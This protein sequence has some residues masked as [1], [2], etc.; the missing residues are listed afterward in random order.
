[1]PRYQ[2]VVDLGRHRGQLHHRLRD[3]AARVFAHRLARGD[4]LAGGGVGAEQDPVAARAL[5]RFEHELLQAVKHVRAFVVQPAP[6]GGDVGQQR[7]LVQVV[8]D[9]FR[10][11]GVD[12]LVV[13]HPVAHR[14]GDHDTALAGGVEHAGDAQHRVRVELQRI[15]ELVVDPPVD[16]V[17]LLLA[18]GGAH[19]DRVV[20]AEQVPALDQL[21]AHL[22][23][24]QRVLEVRGVEDAGG[25]HDDRRIGL[26]RGGRGAQRA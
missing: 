12:E 19:V 13:A 20:P 2:P 14:V 11:V 24:Q 21:D 18:L 9:H 26:V 5:H 1:M 16:H 17:D 6:E 15:Q 23:G 22:A 7:L 25:E 3:P 4:E 10:D 8:R